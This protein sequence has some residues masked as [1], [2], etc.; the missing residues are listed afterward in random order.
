MRIAVAALAVASAG[1][2]ARSPDEA[3]ALAAHWL[4][5]RQ[6]DDGAFRSPA[7]GVLRAGLSTTALVA[8]ALDATPGPLPARYRV[9]IEKALGFLGRA[10]EDEAASDYPNYTAAL[11]LRVLG[12]RRPDAWRV[13]ADRIVARLRAVQCGEARGVARSSDEHGGFDLGATTVALP[14]GAA[15][16]DLSTTA[17]VCEGLRAVD[18]AAD[19]PLLAD[20]RAFALRCST[21]DGGFSF[22]PP[23]PHR[24]GKA[25]DGIAYGTATADGLRALIACGV[26]RDDPRVLAARRWLEARG[27]PSRVPGFDDAHAAFADG[28]RAY[29]LAS[30]ALALRAAGGTPALRDAVRSEAACLLRGDGSWANPS[31]LMKEDDPLVATSLLL[32]ALAR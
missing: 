4:E 12:T 16:P 13:S 27:D 10:A 22:F 20:A 1:A 21:P 18:V 24:P 2:C 5:S 28:L 6:S 31:S 25:G 11:R 14:Q 17:W 23:S 3:E 30:A 32:F 29:W 9:A 19:D 8:A 26:P 15:A 7:Y